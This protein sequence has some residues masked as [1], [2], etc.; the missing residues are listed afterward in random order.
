MNTYISNGEAVQNTPQLQTWY[1]AQFKPNAHQLANVNLQRQGF[2][3]FLPMENVT[4]KSGGRFV[5]KK[6]PLFPGYLFVAFDSARGGWR[7]INSTHGISRVVSFG[8]RPEAVPQALITGIMERCD[9]EGNILPPNHL[10]AGDHVQIVEGPMAE[11]L[12]TIETLGPEQRV[13]VL[14]DI[15]GKQTRVS[16]PTHALKPV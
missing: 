6:R 7:A 1:L 8:G 15:L 12:A 4:V 10:K 14:L 11:F 16:L 2:A 5:D 3:T 13:W 9:G